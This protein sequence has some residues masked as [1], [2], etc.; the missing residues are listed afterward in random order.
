MIAGKGSLMAPLFFLSLAF[1]AAGSMIGT[2]APWAMSAAVLSFLALRH[3]LTAPST[4]WIGIALLAYGLLVT[5]NTLFMSPAYTPAGLYHPLLLVLAYFGIR[6]L[7][8]RPARHAALATLLFGAILAAW[9]L[10]Q[11]GAT[12][13]ARAHAIFE[14]PATYATVLNLLLLPLLAGLLVLR[15]D[16]WL[17]ATAVL[18]AAGLIAADSRGGFLAMLAGLGAALIL[19]VRGNMLQRRGLLIVPVVLASAWLLVFALRGLTAPGV[20]EPTPEARAESSISRLELYSLSL[21]AWREQPLAGTGYLTFRYALES[22]RGQVPSYGTTSETWFVHNDYLQTLQELGPLGL[23][24]LLGLAT[25]PPLLAYRKL[26]YLPVAQRPIVVSATAG[27]VAMA[28]HALVDFPFYIPLC[29]LIYGALLGVIDARLVETP[30]MPREDRPPARWARVARAAVLTVAAIV[31]LRPVAA[32]AAGEWGLRK[33]AAGE[34]QRAAFWLGAAQ[35]LDP[36]D[37]RYHW[38][39]GQFWDAQAAE[40]G[41]PEAAQLAA[42]AYSAGFAANP[43]EVKNLLGKISVHRRHRQL[44]REPADPSTLQQWLAHA[45]ALAP[46]NPA[47]QRELAR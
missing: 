32:E 27:L 43:L 42:D 19:G 4:P 29:L 15:R 36:R 9:G 10:V 7:T 6:K 34:G 28:V 21:N 23:L 31:L 20:V 41:K 11:I 18:L 16:W 3:E 38:Y 44:L 46:L 26:P 33:L 13:V 1:A 24:A 8:D 22:G 47:V 40:S 45:N 30:A 35:R 5:L 12:G 14:T 17:P 25:L 39:A 2:V 37:W